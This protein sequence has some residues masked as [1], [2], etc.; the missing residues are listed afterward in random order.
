VPPA[1]RPL[2]DPARDAARLLGWIGFTVLM[3]GAPLVGVLSRRALFVL[4]PIGAGLLFAAFFVAV[5]TQGLKTLR[6]ALAQP[7]GMAGVLLFVWAGLSLAWTP[8]PREAIPHFI[9]MMAT[10]LLAALLIAQLPDRRA[11][12]TLFLLPAGLAVTA[13]VTL[14]MALVG[15]S[16]FRGGTEFD[17]SLLERSVLTLV[18][19][20]WPALGALAA[21]ERW[22]LASM[23]AILVAIVVSVASAKIAMAV[24]ALS[25]VTF[26]L[27]V[28]EP[29]RAAR[30][31]AVV[32]GS[33][34]VLAPLLP[35]V[36]APLAASISLVGHSTVLAMSDWRDLVVAD[37]VRLIT[38]HGIDT[39]RHG[40]VAGLLPSHTPRTVLFEVWYELGI[41][42]ALAFAAVFVLGFLA[43][44]RAA[45]YVAPALLGGMVAVLGIAVFGVATEDLWFV[46]L[47]SLQAV[48]FGL[49]ARSSRAGARPP[50]TP[51][52][53][54]SS[55]ADPTLSVA[56]R[57]PP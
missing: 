18:V 17:P 43:A 22:R 10:A 36:L 55:I 8:Y 13:L 56:G 19:L 14:G 38:G 50:A 47:A 39:A 23:L 37:G 34:I 5:S 33:L 53:D 45:R 25:A 24:F 4:L 2:A 26:A 27:A 12:P 48:A 6:D 3:I 46:T 49:L 44:G 1:S 57:M 30:V 20:V 41:L 31:A 35:F 52:E 16:S 54:A 15:P 51:A 32:F 7:L 28:S 9:A 21:F 40:V 42:G 29:R 11:R